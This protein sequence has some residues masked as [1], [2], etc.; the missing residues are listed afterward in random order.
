MPRHSSRWPRY[1]VKVNGR[2]CSLFWS[3]ATLQQQPGIGAKSSWYKQALPVPSPLGVHTFTPK[4][5]TFSSTSFRIRRKQRGGEKEHS[6]NAL[7]TLSNSS[8]ALLQGDL[9]GSCCKQSL[10]KKKQKKQPW[11]CK[12][13]TDGTPELAGVT[14]AIHY[15]RSLHLPPLTPRHLRLPSSRA[16]FCT[17]RPRPHPRRPASPPF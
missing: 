13:P 1:V 12:T 11:C 14:R 4:S 7:G 3:S 15:L 17:H 16:A 9:H 6:V 10:S 8:Q 5:Q 2:R